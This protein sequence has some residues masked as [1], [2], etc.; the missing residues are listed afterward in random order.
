MD[1][2]SC[3]DCWQWRLS[4]LEG[5]E[6][7]VGREGVCGCSLGHAGREVCTGD[8]QAGGRIDVPACS[9]SS[10]LSHPTAAAAH[11]SDTPTPQ[12]Q[13][14]VAEPP[15]P[16]PSVCQQRFSQA[17]LTVPWLC[18]NAVFAEFSYMCQPTT[19]LVRHPPSVMS[20][21]SCWL[22]TS[23]WLLRLTGPGTG[24][25]ALNQASRWGSYTSKG[26]QGDT[27]T[28]P[29]SYTLTSV[30]TQSHWSHI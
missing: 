22:A 18:Y 23:A 19:H 12:Q 13:P 15:F 11:H 6:R 9:S 1:S 20:R 4:P 3:T 29:H 25:A 17:T 7:G 5:E 24:G 28:G 16:I 10:Q 27:C 26:V 14:T 8:V 2:E 21:P 30:I